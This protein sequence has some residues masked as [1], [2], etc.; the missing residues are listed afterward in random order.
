MQCQRFAMQFVFL[1]PLT[2]IAL[3]VLDKLNYYGLGT[4]ANGLSIAAILHYWNT[5]SLCLCCLCGPPEILSRRRPGPGVVSAV[6][7]VSVHQGCRLY[8]ILAGTGHFNLGH[9][10]RCGRRRCRAVG[11]VGAKLF[12]LSW[13]CSCFRLHTFTPFR[14][15]NGK[16]AIKQRIRGQ[17]W[18]QY[19]AGDFMQDLKLVLGTRV[20]LKFFHCH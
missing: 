8:D 1:R 7:Q 17:V 16:K 14:R 5:E 15:K 19:C 9:N 12:D 2:S 13:R 18:R 4:S 11:Q 20:T 10:D 3:V 6:C